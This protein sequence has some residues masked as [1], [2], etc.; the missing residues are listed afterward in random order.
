MFLNRRQ[1][2]RRSSAIAAGCI[3]GSRP[4][5]SHGT[6]DPTILQVEEDWEIKVANPDP[7]FNTPEIVTSIGPRADDSEPAAYLLINHE[8]QPSYTAGGIQFQVWQNRQL[9]G[10][11]NRAPFR[12]LNTTQEKIQFTLVMTLENG[13]L[14]YQ[15]T[16]GTSTTFGSFNDLS[17]SV[18]TQL[19]SLSAYD[20]AES[21][22]RSEV[23]VGVNRLS[24]YQLNEVR[25]LLSNDEEQVDDTVRS[26]I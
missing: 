22:R 1:F 19:T 20:P 2:L 23:T 16:N 10:Y 26:I 17:I 9:L 4:G 25:Y 14:N 5:I 12:C 7:D 8:T 24:K 15:V 21:I 11:Q 13:R 18:A 6:P 3:V